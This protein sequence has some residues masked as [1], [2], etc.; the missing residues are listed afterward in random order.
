MGKVFRSSDYNSLMYVLKMLFK[1]VEATKPQASRNESAEIFVVCLGYKNPSFIDSKILDP[2]FALKQLEDEEDMKMN[3]IKSIKAMFEKKKHRAGYSGKL[4][5]EKSFKEFVEATNPYQFLAEYSKIKPTTDDCK[6]YLEVMRCP[7]DYKL[8]FE[9]LQILGKKEIQELIIWRNKIRSK[10]FKKEKKEGDGDKEDDENEN[11]ENEENKKTYKEKKFEE[12]D[13]EMN[14]FERARKTRLDKEKKKREKNELRMK[15][16]FVDQQNSAGVEN[17]VEFDQRLFEYIKKNE[18]DI[19]EMSDDEDEEDNEQNSEIPD[20]EV[21]EVDLSELSE[22]DYI[23]MMNEDITENKKLFTEERKENHKK[24]V[25][26]EKKKKFTSEEEDKEE[27]KLNDGVQYV[28][29]DKDNDEEDEE[30]EDEF[31]EDEEED[32][33]EG[34]IDENSDE[35]FL[36]K[37]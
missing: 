21:D 11:K 23:D 12:M 6:K 36:K 8:Y 28:R 5:N 15:M 20:Q 13:E 24:K 31:D 22:D 2:K 33:E 17:E 25:Q 3:S 7:M 16:S 26:R 19:E 35:E 4:Y 18:I 10:L 14:E 32:E 9:D 1:R 30:D 34:E 29:A 27:N 37:I